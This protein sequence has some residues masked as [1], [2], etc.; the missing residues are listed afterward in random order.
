MDGGGGVAT[1]D[2]SVSAGTGDRLS[3]AASSGTEVRD[4][5]HSHRSVPHHGPRTAQTLG[6][7]SHTLRSDIER[8]PTRLDPVRGQAL[9]RLAAPPPPSPNP[10]HRHATPIPPHH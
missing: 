1:A 6:E 10:S 5:E 7:Q 9:P 8:D 3:H 4:L 2:E